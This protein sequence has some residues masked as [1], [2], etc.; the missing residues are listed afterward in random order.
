MA[1]HE[2]YSNAGEEGIR[3]RLRD[4]ELARETP[5]PKQ[6]RLDLMVSAE[7]EKRRDCHP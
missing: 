3:V 6:S 4:G 1:S 5:N 2:S 7:V